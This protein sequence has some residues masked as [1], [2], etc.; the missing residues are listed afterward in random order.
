MTGSWWG[1]DGDAVGDGPTLLDHA[2]CL[3]ELH[4][5]GPWPWAGDP[6]PDARLDG[7]RP[8]FVGGGEDALL[9]ASPD[10]DGPPPPSGAE[11]ADRLGHL[12]S[13][14]P[15]APGRGPVGLHD[16]LVT[17][18]PIDVADD[19]GTEVRRRGLP[20]DGLRRLGRRLA[21]HGTHR[22]PVKIGLVL[23]GLG[24]DVRDRELLLL[25]GT[26]DE[27]TLYAAVA[28]HRSQPDP[29]P[30]VHALARRV[31]GW[32]RIQAVRLLRDTTDPRIKGWLLREGFRNTITDEYLAHLAA[33]T[34]D[35]R[36][37]LG[38]PDVDGA[39]LDGA[40]GILATMAVGQGGP[41]PGLADYAHAVPVLR[42][43]AHLIQDRTP[44]VA[45]LR[46]LI[47]ITLFLRHPPPELRWPPCDLEDL[48][49]RYEGLLSEPRWP[50]LVLE[51][52]ADP[53]RPDFHLAL[54]PARVLGLD[55]TA[56]VLARLETGPSLLEPTWAHALRGAR[57]PHTAHVLGLAR[58]RLE[59]APE[60]ERE[61]ARLLFPHLLREQP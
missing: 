55:A 1:P 38:R 11:L 27:L 47:G 41:A 7:R 16:L 14:T 17:C 13:A 49:A 23:L 25:L 40:G 21:E 20:S 57:G 4:G 3:R 60:P 2:R 56:Q 45:R 5:P 51:H 50:A 28:L 15:S 37:A 19:L 24:G 30:A 59:V 54:P 34:G 33:T 8:V 44:S 18:S 52:L 35:L 6:L 29:D 26:L 43:Y 22:A 42:R 31:A 53:R 9:R 58:R 39:L 48:T 32:G 46:D 36:G 10:A 61:G 12:L